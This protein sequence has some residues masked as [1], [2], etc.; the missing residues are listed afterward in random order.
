M[1]TLKIRAALEAALSGLTPAL[2]TVWENTAYTPSAGVAY[3][4]AGLLLAEPENPE[5]GQTVIQRGS[6]QVTLMYPQDGGPLPAA[7][8]AE[9]I[10][11]T[12]RRG[13]SLT[14]DGVVT[15]IERT[16]EIAAGSA[17]GDR[18]AVPV[19]VR[20]RSTY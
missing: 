3:Q 17:V 2:D 16:P 19:R 15:M 6:L 5:L 1:S 14:A 13:L 7:T 10:R 8:R 11:A 18:Y 12:F 20:F 9:L 4:S